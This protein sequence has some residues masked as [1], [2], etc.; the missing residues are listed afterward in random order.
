MMD[1]PWILGT[2]GA[3]AFFAAFEARSFAHPDRQNSLSRTVATIGAKWPMSIW[4]MGLGTGI[5][6]SHFFWGWSSNPIAGGG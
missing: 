2:L 5:L 1:L 3:I 6:A 4:L